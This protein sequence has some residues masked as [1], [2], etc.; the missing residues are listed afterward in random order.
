LTGLDGFSKTGPQQVMVGI[1]LTTGV[2]QLSV[3]QRIVKKMNCQSTT[4]TTREKQSLLTID[5]E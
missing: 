3:Q 1:S 5:E 2:G 4:F